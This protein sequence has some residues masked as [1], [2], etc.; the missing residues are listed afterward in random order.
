MKAGHDLLLFADGAW[1]LLACSKCGATAQFNG[2]KQMAD[3]CKNTFS[4][5]SKMKQWTQMVTIHLEARRALANLERQGA[6]LDDSDRE[7]V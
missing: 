5:D 1:E 4:S 6:F 7:E 2:N 3:K